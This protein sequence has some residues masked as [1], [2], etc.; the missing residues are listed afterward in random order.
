MSTSQTFS[1]DLLLVDDS[2]DNLRL[3]S[4]MLTENGYKTRKV[5][6]G[7]RAL[8]AVE[9]ITP[10]LILLDINMPDM[11]GYE[12]CRRL[13]Q[14]DKTRDIPVIFI[15]A[16]DDVFDKVKAFQ[17]GGVDYIT[18][19][20]QIEE[21]LARVNTHLNIRKLQK[22][23]QQQNSQLQEEI[24]HRLSAEE[25]NAQ[26]K[27]LETQLRQQLNVF[28]HAVSHDLRNP[29][30]GTKMVLNNLTNQV[31]ETIQLPRKV[32]ER[33]QESSERQLG[34]I[35]SLIETHAAELWG[36]KLNYQ[37]LELKSLVRSALIDLQPM[38][39]KEEVVLR[40]RIS[41]NLPLIKAD[42]LHLVRVYQ[43]LI[44][45]AL[46]HNPPGFC[47]T[48]DAQ[49]ENEWLRCTVADN[50]VGISKEQ[51]EKIFDLYFQGSHKRQSVGLGLGLYLC[52]HIIQAHGGTIGVESELGIGTTFW[53]T[54]PLT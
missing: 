24:R 35:N 42:S 27:A 48:L 29:V 8:Q 10:D 12:V 52:Q 5:I 3:L 23:L 50:G 18:K 36:L 31:G 47:L 53:F 25:A 16:L 54:L 1:A 34:L 37:P 19:P 30:I 32:L 43:N 9:V 39:D 49:I 2:P 13:K 46:K 26:L 33:M 21:V 51:S 15:S 28:L 14:S 7:E 4:L 11:N 17:A 41:P 38:L 20:F 40:D 6:N 45:N 44:G 22:Q